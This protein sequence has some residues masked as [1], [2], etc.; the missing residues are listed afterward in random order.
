VAFRIVLTVLVAVG[1]AARGR[2]EWDMRDDI[3][4]E[5]S[6]ATRRSIGATLVVLGIV[7]LV[8]CIVWD[9][10]G[11]PSWL[12]AI[13]WVGGGAFGYGLVTLLSARR[14]ASKQ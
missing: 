2:G 5:P 13:T 14:S 9:L 8:V 7:F 3:V 10:N 6:A 11:A 4:T 1:P 12:H